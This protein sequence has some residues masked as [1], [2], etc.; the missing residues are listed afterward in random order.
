M[1]RGEADRGGEEDTGL[2]LID[3]SLVAFKILLGLL[4]LSYSAMRKVGMEA[5]EKED[6]VNDVGRAPVGQSKEESVS[7]GSRRTARR[8]GCACGA[9]V[10]RQ[11]GSRLLIADY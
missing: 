3:N 11:F 5:R 10:R 8:F 1:R 2:E 6:G 7:G 4:L 9:A